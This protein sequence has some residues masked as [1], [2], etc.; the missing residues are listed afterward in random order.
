MTTATGGA[1]V[2]DVAAAVTV[3]AED[4]IASAAMT[5]GGTEAAAIQIGAIGVD[6]EAGVVEVAV[7]MTVTNH[8]IVTRVAAAAVTGLH[9]IETEGTKGRAVEITESTVVVEAEAVAVHRTT[10]EEDPVAE[11]LL[12]VVIGVEATAEAVARI[13]TIGRTGE[14]I[15]MAE[16][17]EATETASIREEVVEVD[18]MTSHPTGQ[19]PRGTRT[20]SLR[21]TGAGRRRPRDTGTCHD[22]LMI[23]KTHFLFRILEILLKTP[24]EC[25]IPEINLPLEISQKRKP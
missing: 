12:T 9:E 10:I 20:G 5:E 4:M 3:V 16:A 21:G 18:G 25:H 8:V 14:T 24:L 1:Q 6:P 11:A 13:V 15:A 17:T 2:E 22:I 23:I 19:D 7:V